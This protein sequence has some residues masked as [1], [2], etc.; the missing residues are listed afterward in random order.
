MKKILF[1]TL[2]LLFGFASY[3][4][5][6]VLMDAAGERIEIADDA[7][8]DWTPVTQT[9]TVSFFY[10][11]SSIPNVDGEYQVL[12][13]GSGS[14]NQWQI[15]FL[16]SSGAT[17]LAWTTADSAW[18]TNGAFATPWTP[19]TNTWYHVVM[20]A[21]TNNNCKIYI[22]GVAQTV[23]HSSWDDTTPISP[24]GIR[25]SNA[26]AVS[27]D[28]QMA[29]FAVFTDEL[30]SAEIDKLRLAPYSMDSNA[31]IICSI[32]FDEQTGT[33]ANDVQTIATQ[34]DGTLTSSPS[35]T[36]QPYPITG[37]IDNFNRSSLGTDWSN[38]DSWTISS[39]TLVPVGNTGVTYTRK[40]LGANY[41]IGCTMSTLPATGAR[42]STFRQTDA[43]GNGYQLEFFNQ[44]SGNCSIDI[45]QVTS[46][47]EDGQIATSGNFAFSAGDKILLVRYGDFLKAFTCTGTTWTSRVETSD[48][49]YKTS[50]Y[51]S[52]SSWD[53]T[54]AR[55]DDLRAGD[56]ASAI[57]PNADDLD[58]FNRSNEDPITGWN[59]TGDD[60]L[61]VVSNQA[62][63]SISSGNGTNFYGSPTAQGAN[64]EAWLTC[65]T[66]DTTTG[67]EMEIDLLTDTTYGAEDGYIIR[68]TKSAGTDTIFLSRYDNASRTQIGDTYNF[69][70]ANNY[71]IGIT[72]FEGVVKGWLNTGSGWDCI[73]SASDSTYS[74]TKYVGCY[75]DGVWVIEDFGG[76][77]IPGGTAT[78]EQYLYRFRN[79][80]G[81]ETSATW[82]AAE[83]T[84]ITPD[85]SATFRLRIGLNSTND[86]NSTQY[87][88]EW[89]SAQHGSTWRK[90]K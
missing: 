64:A 34:T 66:Q 36:E 73:I 47:S 63:L 75:L 88:L 57:F 33:N 89:Y 10:R 61:K 5:S 24:T 43:S 90:V 53:D 74:G 69:E 71:K 14:G 78:L 65:P 27:D 13:Q 4:Y 48:S 12:Y 3:A 26:Y 50:G 37:I 54:T 77:N 85:K 62:L 76:G 21:S 49:T 9:R 68:V 17:N 56:L 79:D 44:G 45:Y 2:L 39:N 31:N 60:N 87:Q 15:L 29:H 35:W 16:Q 22:N 38:P 55:I 52:I 51:L 80:N 7:K 67:K 32:H 19:T 23:T 82:Q 6:S 59:N 58:R 83:N 1:L 25:I 84:N 28:F 72:Y 70:W 41:E 18:T 20:V 86:Y 40:Q 46:G 30:T 81:S 42:S 8:W 11:T